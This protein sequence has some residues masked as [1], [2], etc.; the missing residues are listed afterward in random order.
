MFI[1]IAN[2]IF[3]TPVIG[4]NQTELETYEEIVQKAEQLGFI[5]VKDAKKIEEIR[6]C[7][8]GKI[9]FSKVGYNSTLLKDLVIAIIECRDSF[10]IYS[11]YNGYAANKPWEISREQKLH[12]IYFD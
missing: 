9:H 8:N 3:F 5:L 11:M 7:Y 6:H 2:M 4:E 12:I 1:K 10:L